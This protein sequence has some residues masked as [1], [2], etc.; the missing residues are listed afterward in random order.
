MATI[1]IELPEKLS[2]F[3][4]HRVKTGQFK[5]AGAYMQLLIAEDMASAAVNL[6]EAELERR[7][8]LLLEA[9]D[10]IDRGEFA[11]WEPGEGK[12]ILEGVIR[13]H[14]ENASK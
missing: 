13:R 14:Q 9:V 3:V 1:N 11:P 12:R 5:D 7:D 10:Q 6:S 8:Q 4:D 2:A